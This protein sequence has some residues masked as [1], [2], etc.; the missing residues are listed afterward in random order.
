MVT[1][2]FRLS[3]NHSVILTIVDRFFV[4]LSK[5][6]SA[7]E[8]TTLLVNHVFRQHRIPLD[9]VSDRG[10]QL[11]SDIWKAFCI[12]LGAKVNLSSGYSGTALDYEKNPSS[13]RSEKNP[14]STLHHRSTGLVINNEYSSQVHVQKT[15]P[16]LP[17]SFCQP[18][19]H[20]L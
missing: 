13:Q 17:R 3:L 1:H 16:M 15:G 10:P 18:L 11:V 8:T 4:P 6:P 5:L 19:C 12:A 20:K 9:I 7:L 14:V 2:S